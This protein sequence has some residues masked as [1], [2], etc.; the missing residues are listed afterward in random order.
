MN[1][2]REAAILPA[3]LEA[4]LAPLAA[5]IGRAPG[6]TIQPPQRAP[7]TAERE[8]LA[9]LGGHDENLAGLEL[10]DTL[11]TGGM[12]IVQLA[13]QRRLY[14]KVAV[15]TLRED[16]FGEAA[17][18]ALMQEAWIT[19]ALEHPNV[20]PVYDIEI[21]ARGRPM[22]VLK[23]IEGEPWTAFIDDPARIEREH[24][25]APL[26]WHLEVFM[27]VCNALR[28]AH[29]RGILHR[30]IKPENVMIGAYG[31]VY[32]LDWGIAVSMRP[33]EH[34]RLPQARDADA[35]AGTPS[36]MAPEMMVGD[37]SQL[38][39]HTD[40]YL[41]GATLYHVLVGRPPHHAETLG[42]LVASATQVPEL[43]ES[44][45]A[46]LVELCRRAMD[47]EPTRRP[48]D[49]DAILDAIRIFLRHRSSTDLA[50]RAEG[51][52]LELVEMLDH[53][54]SDPVAHRLEAYQLFTECRFGFREALAS[55][56]DNEA[57]RRGHHDAV[58]AMIDYELANGDASAAA[59]LLS[60]LPDAADDVRTRVHEAL[61]AAEAEAAELERLRAQARDSDLRVGARTRTFIVSLL[62]ILF[63][64][65]PLFGHMD[66]NEEDTRRAL[67]W[68]PVALL[69]MLVA[70][71]WWARESLGKT[72]INRRVMST[73]MLMAFVEMVFGFVFDALNASN[74]II[75]LTHMVVGMLITGVL[76]IHIDRRIALTPVGYALALLA[77]VPWLELRHVWFAMANAV[78]TVTLIVI[79]LPRNDEQRRASAS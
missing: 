34:E 24:Q 19:G 56:P 15:K 48:A 12:G 33:D 71:R 72:A 79:W 39:T 5:T 60:E 44:A 14:R 4:T 17:V 59:A 58:Q 66:G 6:S 40:I 31:E 38:G 77:C 52:R 35:V 10:E 42:E 67:T 47:P 55:W 18:L 37:G 54:G 23:R 78:V 68:F 21:D 13:L 46:E 64:G 45:P 20:M 57:A 26:A 3:A 70:L 63:V 2:P 11:G 53:P 49:V 8:A 7:D 65:I 27:Q 41:L 51:S 29:E 75:E 16:R 62:G 43:P 74:E 50:A 22:V 28:L 9:V 76:A 73:A 32:L 1:Q 25:Q 69:A 36:Y 61:A 30:D